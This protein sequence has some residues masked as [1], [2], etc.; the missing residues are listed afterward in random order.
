MPWLT[1]AY[2]LPKGPSSR[3][4]ALWRRL[5]RLGALGG[6]G[7]LYLLPDAPENLESLQWLAEEIRQTGGEAWVTRAERAAGV[8]D[9]ELRRRFS[10]ARDEDWARLEERASALERPAKGKAP[11]KKR[12]AR[13][14]LLRRL[15]REH[16]EVL[17]L[18]FFPSG[19]GRTLAGRLDRLERALDRERLA[20]PLS[21]P[22]A[23]PA[24]YRRR[25]WVTRPRPHVDRLACVWLI[26]RFIDPGAKVRYAD[27]PRPREVRFDMPGAE[28]GHGGG[29]CS[30]ETLVAAFGL[31]DPALPVVGGI[32]RSID[33]GEP[34][35]HPAAEGLAA[36]LD[37]WR[38]TAWSDQELERHGVALYEGL[39]RT[40]SA[41]SV[42]TTRGRRAAK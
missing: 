2:S 16:G 4:V 39:Y 32:V 12:Q 28:F 7:G 37:G 18:D 11:A 40:L 6:P 42:K 21:P 9:A 15:R 26:R 5:R 41:A 33:L 38:N 22:T 10:A 35:A 23:S 19:R 20:P 14:E 27:R 13:I 36:V 8:A 3:R 17:R 29:R 1:L 34:L 31:E 30:F 24:A 25:Q